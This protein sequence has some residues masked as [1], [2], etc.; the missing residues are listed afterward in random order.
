VSEYLTATYIR[1]TRI[2]ALGTTFA[3]TRVKAALS[4]AETSVLSRATW[5][6]FID[7]K[8]ANDSMRRK[9]WYNTLTEF[10]VPMKLVRLITMYSNET[11]SKDRIGKYLSDSFPIQNGLMQGDVLSQLLFNFALEYAIRKVQEDQVG[12]KLNGHI[13]FSLKLMM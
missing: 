11:Y 12:L 10:G 3:V 9:V 6:I 2:G 8:K 5:R 1:A 7:F 13:S 4:S